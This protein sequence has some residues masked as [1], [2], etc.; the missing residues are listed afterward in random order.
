MKP[1][2]KYAFLSSVDNLVEPATV[3]AALEHPGWLQATKDE[4]V[5][6]E[7]NDTWEL[8]PKTS[9]MHVIGT[10]WVFKIKYKTDN[11]I[12]RL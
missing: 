10:K 3:K 12:E 11:T 9:E 8:V 7:E 1:N 4:L 6:Q 2:L 5:A